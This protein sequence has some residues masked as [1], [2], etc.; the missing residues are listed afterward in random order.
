MDQQ[1]C[2]CAQPQCV[3]GLRLRD[4]PPPPDSPRE[5]PLC[6]VVRFAGTVGVPAG[7][8]QVL[9]DRRSLPIRERDTHI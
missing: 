6:H 3:P 4:L 2:R 7:I 5:H 8:N 1:L 9:R